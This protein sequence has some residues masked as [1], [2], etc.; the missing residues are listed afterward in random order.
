MTDKNLAVTDQDH[1][2]GLAAI[3]IEALSN[4]QA[5]IIDFPFDEIEAA[6]D[7]DLKKY[8]GLVLHGEDPKQQGMADIKDINAKK[9]I[10]TSHT[11]QAI[12][13]LEAPIK[14]FKDRVKLVEGKFTAA[15]SGI[16]E[17]LNAFDAAKKVEIEKSLR[18]FLL[19]EFEA[20]G[21]REEFRKAAID[22]LILIGSATP[23]G[24]LTAKAKS[25]VQSRVTADFALQVQTDMRIAM[26]V[27]TSIDAGLEIPITENN[28]IHFIY[29]DQESYDSKLSALVEGEIKRQHDAALLRAKLSARAEHQEAEVEA[30]RNDYA[31]QN[32]VS[33]PAETEAPVQDA[34]PSNTPYPMQ[35]E[36]F[37]PEVEP[38]A[39]HVEGRLTITAS[40]EI[41][42]VGAGVDLDAVKQQFLEKLSRAE[43][44]T[45]KNVT[46]VRG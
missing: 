42:G 36:K 20:K 40:F 14:A 4:I 15:S 46:V 27:R 35:E 41:M 10:F 28:V 17:Q 45:L 44:T 38:Q 23:K 8:E 18:E 39:Q 30:V 13:M 32:P 2:T 26:L 6:L 31:Q 33:V 25:E 43:F 22:D 11:R 16:R 34:A 19:A 9:A 21:I 37:Y 1:G 24:A 5:P 3:D 7:S 12:T 29:D